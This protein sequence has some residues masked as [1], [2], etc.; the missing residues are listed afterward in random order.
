[1]EKGIRVLSNMGGGV[2]SNLYADVG[3]KSFSSL[4]LTIEMPGMAVDK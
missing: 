4:L 3:G 2:T 1:M